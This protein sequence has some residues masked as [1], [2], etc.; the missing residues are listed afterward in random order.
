MMERKV[1][2]RKLQTRGGEYKQYRLLGGG[3]FLSTVQKDKVRSSM[4]NSAINTDHPTNLKIDLKGMPSSTIQSVDFSE[5]MKAK[6]GGKIIIKNLD[7]LLMKPR[8]NPI[9]ENEIKIPIKI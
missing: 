2:S 1:P 8:N 6:K 9:M 3:G 5:Y 7:M 4:N